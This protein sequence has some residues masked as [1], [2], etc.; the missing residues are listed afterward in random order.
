[1]QEN[2]LRGKKTQKKSSFSDIISQRNPFNKYISKIRL[3]S[4]N[5]TVSDCQRNANS[6]QMTNQLSFCELKC[7]ILR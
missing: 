1:M 3:K 6:P 7:Y 2:I 4:L 5:I